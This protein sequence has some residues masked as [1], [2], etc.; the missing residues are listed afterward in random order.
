LP[1]NQMTPRP[2]LIYFGHDLHFLRVQREYRITGEKKLS[3]LSEDWK[4][5]E[6]AVFEG[7]DKVYYASQVEVDMV[8]EVAPGTDVSAIPL[9][10]LDDREQPTYCWKDRRDIIFVAGFNHPPNVDGLCWFV[11]DVLPLVVEVFPDI[12][13]NVVGAN[14]PKAVMDAASK[15]V[16][17]HG[18]L[19]DEELKLQYSQARVVAVPLRYGAGVKGKVLEALQHGV[20]LVTTPIGAEGLPDADVVF[21]VKETAADFANELI[22]IERGSEERLRKLDRYTNYLSQHFSKTRASEILRRDF[23]EPHIRRDFDR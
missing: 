6:L 12:K 11:D 9:Y 14:A 16:I 1:L 7:F 4:R 15:N 17:I 21:N 13:F 22:E 23:G 19:S 5:R 3:A 2:K 18:Y 8:A 10:V 20:P